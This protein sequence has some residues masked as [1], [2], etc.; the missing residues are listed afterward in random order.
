[1]GDLFQDNGG[2]R[3][4]AI[5]RFTAIVIGKTVWG[6][7]KHAQMLPRFVNHAAPPASFSLHLA[8][9]A[10]AWLA[11]IRDCG[12]YTSIENVKRFIIEGATQHKPTL[13]DS[14][15]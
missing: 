10:P 9:T 6:Y 14:D 15:N 8:R 4:P 11:L 2:T 3:F 1:M 13:F 7:I 12:P 5:G